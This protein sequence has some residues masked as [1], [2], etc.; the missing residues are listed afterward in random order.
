MACSGVPEPGSPQLAEVRCHPFGGRME[1][2]VKLLSGSKRSCEGYTLLQDE[3]E[4]DDTSMVSFRCCWTSAVAG[5]VGQ[6][7]QHMAFEL[8]PEYGFDTALSWCTGK[9][10]SRHAIPQPG[11]NRQHPLCACPV[12]MASL[13]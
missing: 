13:P 5:V 2:D 9:H 4:A 3:A 11:F 8:H 10:S 6:V 1:A 12:A 7:A